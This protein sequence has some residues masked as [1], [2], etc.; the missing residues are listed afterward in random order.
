MA[1]Q[2]L[3]LWLPLH[4]VTALKPTAALPP[5]ESPA[6]SAEVGP[7]A[8]ST[9]SSPSTLM[10]VHLQT[11]SLLLAYTDN[12]A[13][14]KSMICIATLYADGQFYITLIFKCHFKIFWH[15]FLFC[16]TLSLLAVQ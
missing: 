14:Y 3:S 2:P 15:L 16:F 8:A 5:P 4:S 9:V 13:S 10:E 1:V 11:S 12:T 6:P 7:A